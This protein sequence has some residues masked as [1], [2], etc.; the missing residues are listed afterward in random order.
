MAVDVSVTFTGN[1]VKFQQAIAVQ[2]FSWGAENE[3]TV[4]SASGG[5]GAGKAKLTEAVISKQVDELASPLLFQLLTTGGHLDSATFEFRKVG[6]GAP[7][8]PTEKPWITIKLSMVLVT[9]F[10]QSVSAGDESPNEVVHLA[11]GAVNIAI[12]GVNTQGAITPGTPV[13]WNQVTNQPANA[14]TG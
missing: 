13:G 14:I 2:S 9:Q 5:A 10:A 11:Y 3:N 8:G 6:G 1:Q 4:G 12:N 7:A